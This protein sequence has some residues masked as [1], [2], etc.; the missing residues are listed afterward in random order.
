MKTQHKTSY[1]TYSVPFRSILP[2]VQFLFMHTQ[3]YAILFDNKYRNEALQNSTGT[4]SIS[5]VH[6]L[7]RKSH[8]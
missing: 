2:A 5:T 4:W 6:I 8:T 3:T 1:N 7:G